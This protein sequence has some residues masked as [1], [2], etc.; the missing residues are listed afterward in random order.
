MSIK[1]NPMAPE[2]IINILNMIVD[3]DILLDYIY[4]YHIN[5]MFEY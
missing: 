1:T 5:Y 4:S 2:S 3:D